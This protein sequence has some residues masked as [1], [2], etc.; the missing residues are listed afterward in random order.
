MLNDQQDNNLNE[1]NEKIQE[2]E[3][4]LKKKL[5]Q[6]KTIVFFRPKQYYIDLI[7]SKL[8]ILNEELI[9]Y[10]QFKER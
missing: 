1:I 9:N 6:N 10:K 4:K 5:F 2:E 7:D 3:I 8:I